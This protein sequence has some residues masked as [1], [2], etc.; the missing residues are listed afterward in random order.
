MLA[1]SMCRQCPHLSATTG[2]FNF[3][4]S[5][6]VL[7]KLT[8]SLQSLAIEQTSVVNSSIH[9]EQISPSLQNT[10]FGRDV[11]I[12]AR[13]FDGNIVRLSIVA[14]AAPQSVLASS[15]SSNLPSILV[16]LSLLLAFDGVVYNA[17]GLSNVSSDGNAF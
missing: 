12:L 1:H 6:D 5:M 4:R 9:I 2:G 11:R 14:A 3:C 16:L 15:S 7:V 13:A 8:E 17:E 10:M